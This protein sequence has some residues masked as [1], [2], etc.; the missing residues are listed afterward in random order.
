VLAA[1]LL[2]FQ[3]QLLPLDTLPAY[4]SNT[5]DITVTATPG[6]I[7]PPTVTN[8]VGATGVT[9]NDAR[10]NGEITSTG[11]QNPSVWIFWGTV[12]G[13]TDPASW[14]DNVSLGV[15]PLGTFYGDLTDVLVPLTTYYYRCA[16]VNSAGT[17]WAGSTANFTTTV[18]YDLPPP[19]L[20]LTR[21]DANMVTANWTFSGNT[22]YALLQVHSEAYVSD[23]YIQQAVYYG[24][25]YSANLSWPVDNFEL[26]ASAWGFYTDNI[27][28][29][30]TY[31]TASI[32]GGG[33]TDVANAIESLA[34]TF[35]GMFPTGIMLLIAIALF[36]Y[37]AIR[38]KSVILFM[39]L[40]GGNFAFGF[41]APDILSSTETTTPADIAFALIFII[42]A[43]ACAGAAF[44]LMFTGAD[45]Y[46]QSG[47]EE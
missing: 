13:G 10:L 30:S 17:G 6:V 11:N 44:K 26:F 35:S 47:G 41:A 31:S 27:T 18:A 19:T 5:A 40:A 2:A 1:I 39:V 3:F 46:Q 36:S 4:A 15:K 22:T 25:G 8:G 33:M 16:A 21:I 12:D 9:D 45:I 43:L 34:S 23:P 28:Y 7:T 14:S 24:D 42:Y 32:G 29:S 37:M 38:E 20:T